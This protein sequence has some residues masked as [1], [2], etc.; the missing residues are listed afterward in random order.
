MPA[1]DAAVRAAVRASAQR[2]LRGGWADSLNVVVV[3]MK[4][5]PSPKRALHQSRFDEEPGWR[6]SM[7]A[8]EPVVC[9]GRP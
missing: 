8:A 6:L 1:L 7:R 3:P 5:L 4:P 9:G 2:E